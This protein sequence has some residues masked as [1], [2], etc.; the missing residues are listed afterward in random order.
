MWTFHGFRP[1]PMWSCFGRLRICYF[2]SLKNSSFHCF[3]LWSCKPI[4]PSTV[5]LD[6]L[7]P[8]VLAKMFCEENLTTKLSSL[9]GWGVCYFQASTAL[10]IVKES[11]IMTY[12]LFP[13]AKWWRKHTLKMWAS[14]WA[15]YRVKFFLDITGGEKNHL[16]PLWSL[17]NFASCGSP[18]SGLF[19]I[20]V[21][22]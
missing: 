13:N 17:L 5:P 6:N 18:G 9:K 10:K 8:T 7:F 2:S 21:I 22:F 15:I 1:M 12:L 3:L 14:K 11:N 16:V 19:L 20:A 4:L